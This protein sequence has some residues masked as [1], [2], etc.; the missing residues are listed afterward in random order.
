MREEG[1]L[2]IPH[3]ERSEVSLTE[4]IIANYG[5]AV[6]IN[7][8]K[9]VH[10]IPT[11]SSR[12]RRV[13]L[14]ERIGNC[15]SSMERNDGSIIRTYMDSLVYIPSYLLGVSDYNT[16]VQF[17]KIY[18]Y[19]SSVVL[20]FLLKPILPHKFQKMFPYLQTSLYG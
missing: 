15:Y 7:I 8:C 5:F 14:V 4:Q 6:K 2:A 11:F 16:Q 9:C 17:Q 3:T 13:Y 12:R 19:Q 18:I 10:L 20:L 1:L